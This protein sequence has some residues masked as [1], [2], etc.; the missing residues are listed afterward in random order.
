MSL[1]LLLIIIIFLLK[2]ITALGHMAVDLEFPAV[3][4]LLPLT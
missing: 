2:G 1:K 4:P 3:F